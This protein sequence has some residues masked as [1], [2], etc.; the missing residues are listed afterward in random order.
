MMFSVQYLI[1]IGCVIF[2]YKAA[3]SDF[4]GS[5]L[6]PG[7]S[8]L[9]WLGGTHVLHLGLLGCL[10]LQALLFGALTGWNMLREERTS[11]PGRFSRDHEPWDGDER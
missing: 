3:E 1:M 5:F 2:F 10:V 7:I 4:D 6:P 11:T 8:A 9:L